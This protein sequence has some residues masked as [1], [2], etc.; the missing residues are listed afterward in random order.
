MTLTRSA[1]Y[2]AESPT[3]WS[4]P[5]QRRFPPVAEEKEEGAQPK[6][7]LASTACGPEPHSFIHEQRSEESFDYAQDRSGR[8]RPFATLSLQY[9]HY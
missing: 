2:H 1:E 7:S 6:T 3:F 8:L 5:R 4:A 9:P